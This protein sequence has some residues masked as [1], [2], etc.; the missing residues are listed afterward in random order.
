ME[1]LIAQSDRP[2]T[3]R[4]ESAGKPY[5][6]RVGRFDNRKDKTTFVR[7]DRKE[8]QEAEVKAIH[9]GLKEGFDKLVS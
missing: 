2:G 3:V 6:L 8:W 5:H 7:A 4:I 1:W 9:A